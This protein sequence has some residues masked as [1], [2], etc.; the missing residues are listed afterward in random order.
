MW[1]AQ[2]LLLVVVVALSLAVTATSSPR[3]SVRIDCGSSIFQFTSPAGHFGKGLRVVL[4]R[5][6][7]PKASTLLRWP[8]KSN[9]GVHDRFIKFGLTVSAGSSVTLEVPP[10]SHG[11]YG[12]YFGSASPTTIATAPRMLQAIACPRKNGGWTNWAGGY[13]LAKP[14]C[15]PLLVRVGSRSARVNLSLGRR[16]S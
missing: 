12:F 13:L 2:T 16:C 3:A 6:W 15:V 11:V 7:L 10:D 1:I 14:S 8:R 9:L 4:G 5:A